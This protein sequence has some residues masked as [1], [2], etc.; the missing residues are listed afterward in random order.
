MT[1]TYE[2]FPSSDNPLSSDLFV[3]RG[4]KHN[5]VFDCGANE[6]AVEFLKKIEN[7][8]V[9]IS[10]FH[11][12]HTSNVCKTDFISLYGGKKTCNYLH[13]GTV[14]SEKTELEE[15]IEVILLTNCHS[16]DSL[17]LNLNN[18]YLF[19]GDSFCG[20]LTPQGY[21]YNAGVLL[22]TVRELESIDFRYAVI[23]HSGEVVEK[24]RA[25][26]RLKSIYSQRTGNNPYIPV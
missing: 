5:Y 24:N 1:S 10:H 25:V 9:V 20:C 12:D 13:T 17:V 8:V 16:K 23:S 15:G 21:G 22:E 14:V 3:I 2:R 18:E 7:K 11:Q 19:V 26:E 4:K 6:E